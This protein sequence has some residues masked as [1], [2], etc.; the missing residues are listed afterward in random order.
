[1]V[2]IYGGRVSIKFVLDMVYLY[3]VFV[4]SHG[5]YCARV[6]DAIHMTYT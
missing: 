6:H 5:L 2:Y 1:M 3:R 4:Y